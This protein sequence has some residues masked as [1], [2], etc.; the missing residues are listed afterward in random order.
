M[1][2]IS[3]VID[4]NISPRIKPL[5]GNFAFSFVSSIAIFFSS[6]FFTGKTY[7]GKTYILIMEILTLKGSFAKI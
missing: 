1:V 2:V 7:H 6:I 5:Q 4:A 3:S